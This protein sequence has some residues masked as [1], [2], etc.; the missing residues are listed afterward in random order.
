MSVVE[1]DDYGNLMNRAQMQGAV[2]AATEAAKTGGIVMVFVHGWHHNASK[3]AD[4]DGKVKDDDNL[5]NFKLQVERVAKAKELFRPADAKGRATEPHK[6]V[7]GIYVGW[8][9]ESIPNKGLTTPASY[10]LTFWGRKEAAHTIGLSGGVY[11]LFSRL[12]QIRAETADAESKLIITGHSFGGAVVYSSLSNALMEQ[13]RS[14]GGP[15]AKPPPFADLIL[16]IN[17]A[18][19]AMRIRPQLDLARRQEY[20]V[21]SKPRL[22]ILTTDADKATR[23]A[24]PVGR[25]LSTLFDRY[26]DAQ[27]P[28]E[29]RHAVGHHIPYV[30]HQ[31]IEKPSVECLDGDASPLLAAPRPMFLDGTNGLQDLHQAR[32]KPLCVERLDQFKDG[33]SKAKELELRRCDVQ[34]D[35]TVVAGDHFIARGAVATGLV[36]ERLPILNIRTTEAVMDGHN[37]LWNPTVENFALQLVLLASRGDEVPMFRYL[38]YTHRINLGNPK[39]LELPE[40]KPKE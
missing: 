22:I 35:C 37:D 21:S 18:F 23:L 9:G 26:A 39:L 38:P 11:E 15:G 1:Y 16:L 24:F 19:E 31:L 29:N 2:A 17:P 14:D 13:I 8:R 20:P 4:R 7:L 40:V 5:A 32:R 3:H 10:L 25:S 36:P 34:G 28:D 33:V 6:K 30:T 12:S 27:S